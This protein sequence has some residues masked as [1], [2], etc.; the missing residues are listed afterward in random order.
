MLGT[1]V[2]G[3]CAERK[4]FRMPSVVRHRYQL[5]SSTSAASLDS[6]RDAQQHGSLQ[7][8]PTRDRAVPQRASEEHAHETRPG[9][10]STWFHPPKGSDGTKLRAIQLGILRS[11]GLAL[12]L[13]VGAS[14][15]VLTIVGRPIDLAKER[16]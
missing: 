5:A 11:S 9:R 3:S 15:G 10:G 4:S 1:V 2:Q 13:L 12:G 6:P 8:S 7:R 16:T 14:A